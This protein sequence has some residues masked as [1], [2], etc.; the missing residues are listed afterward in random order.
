MLGGQC[1]RLD[2]VKFKTLAGSRPEPNN[3]LEVLAA[4]ISSADNGPTVSQEVSQ[5]HRSNHQFVDGRSAGR[6]W[7][8]G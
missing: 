3:F 6:S 8:M 5:A 4:Q 2:S 1:F 7:E